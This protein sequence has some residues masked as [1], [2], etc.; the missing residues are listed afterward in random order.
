MRCLGFDWCFK[1]SSVE[2]KNITQDRSQTIFITLTGLMTMR[3]HFAYYPSR[4]NSTS[5]RR[6]RS[7]GT[8]MLINF[9]NWRFYMVCIRRLPFVP[10]DELWPWLFKNNLVPHGLGMDAE[11]GHYWTHLASKVVPNTAD[12]PGSGCV[13]LWLWGDDT[14]YN[15]QGAKIVVVAMGAMMD[16]RKSSKD[17]VY[18]I[19][20][21]Q[22]DSQ[23]LN[24]HCTIMDLY[25]SNSTHEAKEQSLGFETLQGFLQPVLWPMGICYQMFSKNKIGVIIATFEFSI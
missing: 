7:Q 3:S 20:C 22:V 24:M 6:L 18:L 12:K 21:Y 1:K 25:F 2:Y 17:T 19:F 16:R 10:P 23:L 8:A 4:W 15:E 14:R 13:P 5:S 11:I 9:F